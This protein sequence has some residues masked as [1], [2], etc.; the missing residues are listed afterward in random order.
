MNESQIQ[1]TKIMKKQLWKLAVP[2][3]ILS[4]AC[5]V[6]AAS[7]SYYP[8]SRPLFALASVCWLAATA[9]AII[10]VRKLREGTLKKRINTKQFV[11]MTWMLLVDAIFA[12]LMISSL[13][14]ATPKAEG[15]S[16][17]IV[18]AR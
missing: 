10:Q 4:L 9:L 16:S 14:A 15:Y 12:I 8:H 11:V 13:P 18:A 2:Y 1:P 17:R 6:F 7:F 5:I 3:I